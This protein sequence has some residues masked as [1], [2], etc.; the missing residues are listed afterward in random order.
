MQAGISQGSVSLYLRLRG[1]D[2]NFCEIVL[3]PAM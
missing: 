1:I 2:E 3:M